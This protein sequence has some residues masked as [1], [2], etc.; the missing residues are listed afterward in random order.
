MISKQQGK[1]VFQIEVI[2]SSKKK[3]WLLSQLQNERLFHCKSVD[4]DSRRKK[5]TFK[6]DQER[7]KT[8]ALAER[9]NRRLSATVFYLY[10]SHL[11]EKPTMWYPNRSDTNRPVQSQKQARSLKF[12][13]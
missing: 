9:T 1:I 5:K 13:S 12:W 4:F 10:L 7:A 2:I 6:I 11:M 3:T 8:K